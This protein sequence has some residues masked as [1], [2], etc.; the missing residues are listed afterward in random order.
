MYTKRTS[1]L[2]DK[3]ATTEQLIDKIEELEGRINELYRE[4]SFEFNQGKAQAEKGE[5]YLDDYIQIPI[6]TV[7][8]ALMKELKLDIEFKLNKTNINFK[9]MK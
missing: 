6:K 1:L 3:K 8:L 7:L 2:L 5:M 4:N 9:K